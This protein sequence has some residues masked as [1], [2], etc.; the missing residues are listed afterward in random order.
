MTAEGAVGPVA[1]RP[2]RAV[3]LRRDAL[4][5]L[6][7]LLAAML[8][9]ALAP[10][11]ARYLGPAGRGEFAFFQAAVMVVTAAA[12]GGIR[13]AYYGQALTGPA[14]AA[15]WTSRLWGPSIGVAV[16]AGLPLAVIAFVSLDPV[17]AVGIGIVVLG[18]PL[19]A[20]LQLEMA[21][22][23]F[24]QRQF[25]VAALSSAPGYLEFLA[26]VVLLA[27]RALTLTAAVLVTVA[28]ELVRGAMALVQRRRDLRRSGPIAVDREASRQLARRAVH[29]VPATLVPL[30]ATNL[31]ALVYGA[32]AHTAALG[33]YAV[34]K[35]IPTFLQLAASVTEGRFIARAAERGTLRATASLAVPLVALAGGAV[36]VGWLV[37]EPLFGAPFSPAR[38]AFAVTAGVGVTGAV[39]VWYVAACARRGLPRI[40]LAAS[41]L[42]LLVTLV[43]TLAV[44]LSP[45]PSPVVMGLPV[46]VGYTAGLL[47]IA[48]RLRRR[49]QPRRS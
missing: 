46:L 15:L 36:V 14:R 12:G 13:H 40:S 39:Y 21:E 9:L 43:G 30:A 6:L 18:A 3:R 26:N 44:G 20:L 19:Y 34:A 48:I 33:V 38:P 16:L 41:V 32:L 27:V 45:R 49:R 2:L 35:L 10:L 7:V 25:R 4:P 23:Q 11:R 37:V 47:M 42:V 5:T 31:D 24:Q 17:V 22:A 1:R 29:F 28:S 8:P